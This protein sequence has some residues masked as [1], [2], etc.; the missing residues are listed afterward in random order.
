LLN[1]RFG[2]LQQKIVSVALLQ[3]GIMCLVDH[4]NLNVPKPLVPIG[5]A[6]LLAALIMAF[7]LNC[8]PALNP[9]R[10]IPG[11]IFANIVGYGSDVWKPS[12]Y[13]YWL[14]GGLIGLI[15]L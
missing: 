2:T 6:L 7:G 8:G 5:L 9:A 3:F 4:K 10:D 11:R 14:I 13:V 1:F 12:N 15:L